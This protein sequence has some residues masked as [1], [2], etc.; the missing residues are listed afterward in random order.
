VHRLSIKNSID[1]RIWALQQK[2]AA[3]ADGAFGEAGK[4]KVRL[5]LAELIGLFGFNA[6]GEDHEL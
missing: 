4:A 3:L 6:R 2:K 5:G 1:E